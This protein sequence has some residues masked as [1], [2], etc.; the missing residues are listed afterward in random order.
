MADVVTVT[1]NVRDNATPGVVSGLQ[2]Q[3]DALDAIRA[4][5]DELRGKS[6]AGTSDLDKL[7]KKAEE[8]GKSLAQMAMS[9]ASSPAGMTAI[10]VAA[11]AVVSALTTLVERANDA[12]KRTNELNF[13]L[14]SFDASSITTGLASATKALEEFDKATLTGRFLSALRTPGAF[15]ILDT[16]LGRDANVEDINA[17]RDALEKLAPV[18]RQKD[19]AK[20]LEETSKQMQALAQLE[21]QRAGQTLDS[22]G[23]IA[24]ENRMAEAIKNE[25]EARRRLIEQSAMEARGR[26][27]AIGAGP[28][29]FQNIEERRQ[30]QLAALGLFRDRMLRSVANAREQGV[31]NLLERQNAGTMT[32]VGQ[33]FEQVSAGVTPEDLAAGTARA[34]KQYFDRFAKE[35]E[36]DVGEQIT[37]QGFEAVGV[38]PSP[39]E[40]DRGVRRRAVDEAN[41][42]ALRQ[43]ILDVQRQAVGLSDEERDA[44]TLQSIELEKQARLTMARNDEEREYINLIYQTQQANIAREQQ[45]RNDPRAGLA[46][47]FRQQAELL[48][49][50]GTIM[51]NLARDTAR[52]MYQGFSD[53]LFQPFEASL[54]KM[55]PMV[56]SIMGGMLRAVSDALG[57]MAAG[58]ILN[59]I[60]NLLGGGAAGMMAL[61]PGIGGPAPLSLVGGSTPGSQVV[62]GQGGNISSFADTVTAYQQGGDQAV[63]MLAAGRGSLAGGQFIP[64]SGDLPVG[65]GPAIGA[66]QRSLLSRA[67][68]VAGSAAALGASAFAASQNNS[69]A[70]ILLNAGL[71]ALTGAA[72]GNSLLGSTAG[73][74]GGAVVGAG[75]NAAL[76][77]YANSQAEAQE[78][79]QRQI[80]EVTRATSAGGELVQAASGARDLR[81]F[82]DVLTQRGAPASGG[83]S[84]VHIPVTVETPEGTKGVGMPNALFPTASI[85][86]VLNNPG[87]LKANIV[88]GVAPEALAG[89]NAS[90]S[91]GLQAIATGL[92]NQFRTNEAG[93]QASTA[94]QIPGELRRTTTVPAP[95]AN[96]LEGPI[97]IEAPGFNRLSDNDKTLILQDLYALNQKRE[98]NLLTRDPSTNGIVSVTKMVPQTLPAPAAL[99]PT[100]SGDGSSSAGAS[101]SSTAALLG[102]GA[103]AALGVAADLANPNG[104]LNNILPSG[105]TGTDLGNLIVDL[106]EQSLGRDGAHVEQRGHVEHLGRHAPQRGRVDRELRSRSL[107]RPDQRRGGQ[108]PR[109]PCRRRAG[110]PQCGL[111]RRGID[112][113][114]AGRRPVLDRA[115]RPVPH[116]FAGHGVE[117]DPRDVAA[118][119]PGPTRAGSRVHRRCPRDWRQH[120]GDGRCRSGRGWGHGGG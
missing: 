105:Y 58:P 116:Q 70:G 88:A 42:L 111:E 21:A 23:F 56:Q 38:G 86:D 18:E 47:G 33:G 112:S 7:G 83:S 109:R 103:A 3:G 53:G 66:P 59:G 31:A 22:N 117:L 49:Q 96:T 26:A 78:K 64:D 99:P 95:L 120:R 50:Q 67:L 24:A 43:Q 110:R 41:M 113:E 51:Q 12:A 73:G 93:V 16:I 4:K 60:R 28:G 90:T 55:P 80:A 19:F 5:F 77:A 68:P 9:L 69:T 57:Q 92:A 10:G 46:E 118:N 63:R 6:A 108:Y 81:E 101:G 11:T 17:R 71:G 13:A 52:A 85:A 30:D 91:A 107:L 20:A 87:S 102:V 37:G 104:L 14:K 75:L 2:K 35:L 32:A 29:I 65:G 61:A 62:L 115:E 48:G 40:V 15:N 84:A 106:L 119:D 79:R 94:V 1:L 8:T 36:H 82:F 25:V 44:L 76:A 100:T 45:L 97:S 74:V 27:E 114:R 39:L 34:I 54:K 72:L 98:L 89:A